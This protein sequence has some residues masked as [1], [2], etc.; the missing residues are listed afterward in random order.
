M[1]FS[2][3]CVAVAKVVMEAK[4]NVV[5]EM[6][7]FLETKIEIDEDLKGI[8]KE[9]KENLKES[10]EKMVKDSGKGKKGKSKKDDGVEKK[11]RAPSVFNLY[12]KDVMPMLKERHP[13][14][15]NGKELISLA[16]EEWKTSAKAQFI[17]E[18]VAELKKENPDLSGEQLFNDAKSLYSDSDN[19][20]PKKTT[21]KPEVEMVNE[22]VKE[23][24]KKGGKAAKK[25]ETKPEE[26]L[27]KA[28][29]G[30][31]VAKKIETKPE[32]ELEKSKKGG[33]A[34][35]KIELEEIEE[36]EEVNEVDED[37]E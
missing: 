2:S 15:K 31:K 29:K 17:K 35:K 5:D 19:E 13:E 25:I 34:A 7:A 30:G 1:A 26:E 11:K 16:G 3:V 21:T 36:E 9:F 24:P 6:V 20:K 28:K 23:K 33:K 12:V 18:K 22:D 37:D 8:F 27:E 32:E 14:I 4:L 10:E